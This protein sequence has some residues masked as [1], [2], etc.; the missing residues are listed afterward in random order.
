MTFA[1][2]Y[3]SALTAG[4]VIIMQMALMYAVVVE[5]RRNRQ[6]VGDGGHKSLLLAIRRHGNL[7]ENAGIFVAGFALLELIGG[8]GVGHAVLCAAFVL[9]RVAHVIG[10]SMKN[11]VNPWRVGGVVVTSI[12]GVGLGARLVLAAV[13]HLW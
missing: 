7:A 9:G 11:T 1:P 4:I 10:L 2:P 5:R 6:S 3:V 13:G 12:V 8:G